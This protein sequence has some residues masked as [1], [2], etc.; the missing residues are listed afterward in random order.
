METNQ[1]SAE[2]IAQLPSAASDLCAGASVKV[3]GTG[4][5]SLVLLRLRSAQGGPIVSLKVSNKG[6][7]VVRS[8]LAKVQTPT[9][10]RL[11]SGWNRLRVCG[12][13]GPSGRWDVALND[14]EIL[15]GWQVNTGTAGAGQLV[16]GDHARKT[17]S[18]RWD[19][20]AVTTGEPA[21]PP[22]PTTGTTIAAA[23][24]PCEPTDLGSCGEGS[25]CATDYK[26]GFACLNFGPQGTSFFQR[27]GLPG[28][29]Q[30]AQSFT[31]LPAGVYDTMPVR[32]LR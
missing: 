32:G 14:A 11:P 24:N 25:Y 29:S 15:S 8:D 16:L 7:L 21:P 18:A 19:D 6:K 23:G 3:I 20:V 2:L 28:G 10:V 22:P 13:I 1:S 12:T 17:A 5:A 9:G 31:E 30:S 27:E 26:D 4:G